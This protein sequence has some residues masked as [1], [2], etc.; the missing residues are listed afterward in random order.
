MV[1]VNMEISSPT[2]DF[3]PGFR[4]TLVLLDSFGSPNSRELNL[5]RARAAL[6]L[7]P[8][9]IPAAHATV[10]RRLERAKRMDTFS[11]VTPSPHA[12][13]HPILRG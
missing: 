10:K 1:T 6:L 9:K 13:P 2:G 7:L 11:T 12:Y 8:P 3:W 4:N 5:R